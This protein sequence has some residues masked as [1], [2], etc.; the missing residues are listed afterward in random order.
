MSL[1]HTLHGGDPGDSAQL[2]D[3]YETNLRGITPCYA[4][5][6][7]GADGNVYSQLRNG[8]WSNVGQWLLS[9]AAAD[10][11]VVR[12]LNSGSLTTDAGAGPLALSSDRTYSIS[13]STWGTIKTTV[14]TLVVE[15]TTGGADYAERQYTLVAQLGSD[16]GDSLPYW[17]KHQVQK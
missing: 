13:N 6:R 4:G 11:S 17:W 12:T 15:A 8:N 3:V 9:G 10:F 14:I 1:M 2:P 5:I 7:L 16:Q